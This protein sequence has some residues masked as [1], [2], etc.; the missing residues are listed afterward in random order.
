M[1]PYQAKSLNNGVKGMLV[2]IKTADKVL[3]TFNKELKQVRNAKTGRFMKSTVADVIAVQNYF[4]KQEKKIIDYSNIA[5][6]ISFILI[7]SMIPALSLLNFATLEIASQ[8]E[9]IF[10]TLLNGALLTFSAFM[11]KII[12]TDLLKDIK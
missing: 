1:N 12:I 11:S 2:E 7:V 10:A 5:I 6:A 8:V 4:T 9:F 3:V